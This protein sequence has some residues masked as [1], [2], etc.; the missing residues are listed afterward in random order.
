MERLFACQA[1]RK[2]C[3][4]F[5]SIVTNFNCFC[6]IW[7]Y[8]QENSVLTQLKSELWFPKGIC[9]DSEEEIL[10]VSNALSCDI[11]QLPV[12]FTSTG[13]SIFAEDLNMHP[14]GLHYTANNS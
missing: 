7:K 12:S 3:H 1:I 4:Y 11:I 14:A 2:V 9:F 6:R 5:P 8:D 13:H 10:F